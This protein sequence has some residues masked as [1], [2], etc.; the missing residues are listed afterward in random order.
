MTRPGRAARPP[1]LSRLVLLL[2]AR[3]TYSD[4][5]LG[6]LEEEFQVH[7]VPGRGVFRARLW[8]R[9]QALKSLAPL[10]A[11]AVVG[12]RARRLPR[13]KREN[14]MRSLIQDVRFGLRG[15][16]RNLGFA[17]VIVAT[18]ALGIGANT[19]LYSVVDGL[20][21][22][23]FPFP[24]EDRLITVGTEY[25][26]LGR[27]LDFVEHMS[28]AEYV[29]IR[30]EVGSLER[31]VAW[32]MGNRQVSWGELTDNLF[33]G[34]WWGDAF[35]TLGMTPFLG[36]GMT[37]EETLG[38][39]RVAVL[40]HRIWQGRL[41]ADPDIVGSSIG[42]NG[43]PYTVIGIMRPR[44]ELYGMDLWMPMGVSPEVF[45]RDRRQFQVLARIG[46]GYDMDAVN[47]ELEVLARRAEREYAELDEYEGWRMRAATWTDANVRLIKPAG[48]VL[49]GA[50][51]FVL[52]LV[53]SNVASLLLARSAA[54]RREMAVRTAMGAN[55]GRLVRQMLTESVSLALVSCVL[56]VGLAYL[57]TNAVAGIL[58]GVPFLPGA[59]AMNSRVLVFAVAV[60]VSSGVLFGILPALQDSAVGVG[61]TLKSEG[62][63]ATG[64]VGRLRLQR[65]LVSVEVALALLL[66]VGGG[67]F[68][69]SFS[70]L[71]RVE[72]GFSPGNVMS[73]RLTL[74]WEEYDGPAIGAFFQNL[75]DQVGAIPGV[76]RVGRGSQFPPIAFSFVRVA[77]EGLQVTDEGRLP[78]TMATI[79][80]PGYFGAL[81]IPLE[82]GRLFD[83][84][85]IEGSPLVGVINEAAAELMFPGG[86]ALGSRF[87]TGP[88]DD[89]P[90]FEV[91]GIVGNTLNNGLDQP[92]FPEVFGNHRQTPSWSNQL[93]LLVRTSVDPY[94][95][96]PAV[97][98]VVRSIDADQPI[99]QIRTVDEALAAGI[100]PRWVAAKVLAVFA[101]VALLLAAVGIFAVVSFAVGARTREIGLRVALGAGARQVRSLVIRQAL[102]PVAIGA[103]IGLGSALALGRLLSGLLFEV[104]GTDPLTLAAV[105]VLFGLVAL[106]ASYLPAR[107]ASRLDPVEALR[108][109]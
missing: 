30:D 12:A 81:G 51:T 89:D 35:A 32:D 82:R 28:P 58:S 45:S 92:P 26:K 87:R 50:V 39:D 55:R 52:L 79:A 86:D 101:G 69:N 84:G 76:E 98:D 65:V 74:P 70:R 3:S 22:N 107:R 7:R 68:L 27:A 99:Y 48:F 23:P 9:G 64:G 60:S 109:E 83:D 33:S 49:L 38:G 42:I 100:A 108:V 94:S 43:N 97:R 95:V 8:Y 61:A 57:G 4:A 102:V 11:Q 17:A 71:T 85:D 91:V 13:G 6:D 78:T 62:T 96:L 2:A 104:G 31:V 93:F 40:S 44:A 72:P 59:V 21:L 5:L 66:L 18:L 16:R 88:D 34:F 73:M 47:A 63:S 19:I 105:T 37:L 56:G 15:M 77:T 75:E 36:R 106:A 20:I 1:R 41:G 24:D 53:C 90:W 80:S 103:V 29:D 54:R 10:L 46:A 25:P 67:L 14:W